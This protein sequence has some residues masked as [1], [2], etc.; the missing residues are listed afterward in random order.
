MTKLGTLPS[1]CFPAVTAVSNDGSFIIRV[2]QNLGLVWYENMALLRFS[3]EPSS[4][5]SHS[6]L[7]I[8]QRYTIRFSPGSRYVGAYDT[9]HAFV[10]STGSHK[11]IA[12]YRVQIFRTWIFNTGLEPPCLHDI[13][14]PV[15]CN[16]ALP[17]VPEDGATHP[18][19]TG[20]DLGHDADESWLKHPFYDLSPS[21]GGSKYSV[22]DIYSSAMG[23]IPL[24][25]TFQC[26]WFNGEDELRIPYDYAPTVRSRNSFSEKEAWYGDLM[27]KDDGRRDSD[28]IYFPRASKNGTRFLL[29][30]KLK[31]PVVVDI[32]Q[33]V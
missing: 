23:R 24:T 27:L 31:A 32:S 16:P 20:P 22:I 14:M 30:G 2:P 25:D 21:V 8:P 3:G 19:S 29:Q 5:Q 9:N 10:W 18:P 28:S 6:D 33:I 1:G 26:I 11:W 7:S 13:P 12:Q 4:P 15:L 17:L